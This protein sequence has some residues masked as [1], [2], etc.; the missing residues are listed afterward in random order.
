MALLITGPAASAE[1]SPF[2]QPFA[3]HGAQ[4]GISLE[5][6]RARPPP[7]EPS[8]SVAPRCWT[9]PREADT[10]CSYGARFG[11]YV[12]PYALPLAGRYRAHGARYRFV[13]GG[14]SEIWLHA[15]I[16]SFSELMARL[17]RVYGPPTR[18]E[19]DVATLGEGVRRPRVRIVWSRPRAEVVLVDPS[20]NATRLEVRLRSPAAKPLWAGP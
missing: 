14:L 13:R 2:A 18:I 8:P 11:D 6:W 20:D 19:R 7:G 5:A 4:L 9:G 1:P 16:D 3:F 10:V 15:S 12:L 17:K